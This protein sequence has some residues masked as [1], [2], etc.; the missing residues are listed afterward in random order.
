MCAAA[1]LKISL[2]P[3]EME[4]MIQRGKLKGQENFSGH[5]SLVVWCGSYGFA[6]DAPMLSPDF[7]LQLKPLKCTDTH[8][9]RTQKRVKF[10]YPRGLIFLIIQ[11]TIA[12]LVLATETRVAKCISWEEAKM[13]SFSI[14][15]SAPASSA[16]HLLIFNC[17]SDAPQFF[18]IA[19]EIAL[20]PRF[21]TS[22]YSVGAA[23]NFV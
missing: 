20:Y 4:K 15:M 10:V 14:Q 19:A 1:P 12:G 17:G 21:L 23:N 2:C 7:C 9:T 16:M 13:H 5:K 3:Q 11:L 18:L 6:I 8:N 22:L